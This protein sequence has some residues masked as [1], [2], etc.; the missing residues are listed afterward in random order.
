MVLI[1]VLREGG[2]RELT[3]LFWWCGEVRKQAKKAGERAER[4]FPC[5][6]DADGLEASLIGYNYWW[7]RETYS[8]INVP[9]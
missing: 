1:S 8:V 3:R 5:R 9:A 2:A 4:G 6:I 7:H